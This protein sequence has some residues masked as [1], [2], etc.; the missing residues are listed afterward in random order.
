MRGFIFWTKFGAYGPWAFRVSSRINVL[1]WL[2]VYMFQV[3]RPTWITFIQMETSPIPVKG[4]T[5]LPIPLS[6]DGSLAC[7]AYCETGCPFT[8]VISEEQMLLRLLP[9]VRQWSCH[10]MFFDMCLSRLVFEH[11]TFRFRTKRSNRQHNCHCLKIK[12]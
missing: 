10:Y 9:S 8:T 1:I 12:N 4:C 6:S 2:F 3:F 7:H 11:P 5:F